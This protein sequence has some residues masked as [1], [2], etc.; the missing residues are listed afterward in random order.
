VATV[1]VAPYPTVVPHDQTSRYLDVAA[2]VRGRG[3]ASVIDDVDARLR[4]MPMPLEYHA[5]VLSSVRSQQDTD[6]LVIGIAVAIVIGI[7][8]LL[9]AA[10]RD[11]KLATTVLLPLPLA[12]VGGVLTAFA[13]GGV[14]SLGALL[15]LATVL[16]MAVRNAAL[17][18]HG[19][20]RSE[21]AE[22]E[23]VLD[24][25]LRA[26]RDR[27]GPVLLTSVAVVLLAIPILFFGPVAGFEVLYPWAVVTLGGL[28]TSVALTLLVLP[29]L[30][31]KV[32]ATARPPEHASEFAEWEV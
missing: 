14:G 11:W 13:A 4:T 25:V 22:D 15:G 7:F 23:S 28:A 6:N 5:E 17:L 19:Y 31:L 10:F 27:V 9:Q 18:V 16:T 32:A 26:T 2:D 12:L 29:A 20:Q 21:R 8:L 30:Y 1:D 3:L 24:L